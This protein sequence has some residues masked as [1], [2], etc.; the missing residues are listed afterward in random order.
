[1]PAATQLLSE[2]RARLNAIAGDQEERTFDNTMHALDEL[3][4]P[5]DY[6]MGVVRHLE[7]VATYPELR[8]AFNAVQPEVSA[9]YS[10][11]PLHAGLWQRHQGVSPPPPK[12]AAL[13]RRTP[14]L[15]HQDHRHLPPPRRRPRPG[16]QAAPGSDRR[17]ADHSSPPSSR[18]NVLDSTNAF[19]LVI[20]DEADLAGLPPTAV[21]AARESAA[22]KG[23]EGWR[24]TLQAPGLRRGDDLP[25]RRRH[26]PRRC[27]RPTPCAPPRASATTAR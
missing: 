19:E 8:A 18:E 13:D 26:P 23:R 3:T 25:G 4:E 5:L 14:A 21:A 20:T 22:R 11:I 15:P 17:R 2:A 24:F 1:M 27:T 10:G 16:G 7:S 12:R 9:F 6:A